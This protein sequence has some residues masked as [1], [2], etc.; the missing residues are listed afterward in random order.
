MTSL[1]VQL[2]PARL[3]KGWTQVQLARLSGVDQGMISRIENGQTRGVGFGIVERLAQA[4]GV[5]S[6][7]LLDWPKPT[8]MRLRRAGFAR[9]V[10]GADSPIG[11]ERRSERRPE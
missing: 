9:R 11:L 2:R 5:S 3:E 10:Y 1:T 7:M 4:L 8:R 6:R